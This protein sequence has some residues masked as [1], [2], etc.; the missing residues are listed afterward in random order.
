MGTNAFLK[1]LPEMV[2]FLRVAEL[3]SFSAAASELGMTPSAASRQVTR[4][5][6]ELGVQLMQR[7]TRQLRLSEPGIEAFAHCRDLVAAAQATMQV[8]QQFVNEPRGQVRVS[9]PKAFARHVL[10]PLLMAFLERYPNVDIQLIVADRDIDP[11]REGVDLVVRL[12]S[13]PPQGLVARPLTAVRQLLCAA[14]RYLKEKGAIG[15]PRDLLAHSCLYLGEQERD[16]RW[17][18][19]K[20][21]EVVD[22]I[23]QG[24]YVANHSEIRLDAVLG[25]LGVGCVP[26]FV[27]RDALDGGLI[28]PVLGDWA[29]QAN[30]HG[31]AYLLFPSNSFMVSKCRVL[32]DH[33]TSA[34]QRKD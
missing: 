34:L 22:V 28:V 20:G 24:R 13:D 19:C 17:R 10:H 3:G 33:L 16:N 12:T 32:I 23:V 2:T 31:Q 27:A 9:A 11:I 30:Y 15:H 5:E 14:P 26:D 21:D 29:F 25:G 4:L 7:T 8:A 18:F 1:I 6:K